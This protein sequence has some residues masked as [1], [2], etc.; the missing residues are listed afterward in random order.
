MMKEMIEEIK[1]H[2]VHYLVLI[3]ILLLGGG[4]FLYF[5]YLRTAQMIVLLLTGITYVIWGIVHH[6]LEGD[7]HQKIILEYLSTA[8][9][10]IILV[11][12]LLLRA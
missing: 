5:N 12:F 4:A 11:W 2:F 8:I 10:G 9:L 7:L 6:S 1:V 3:I